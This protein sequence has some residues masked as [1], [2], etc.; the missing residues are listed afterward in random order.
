MSV[1]KITDVGGFDFLRKEGIGFTACVTEVLKAIPTIESKGIYVHMLSKPNDWKFHRNVLCQELGIGKDKLAIHLGH[2]I[3]LGL[4]REVERRN[5]QGQ[6]EGIDLFVNLG[7]KLN[8]EIESP[9]ADYPAPVKTAS[10]KSASTKLK[11]INKA[12]EEKQNTCEV[13][14]VFDYW[15][16]K[17]NRPRSK[18]DQKR[19]TT[20][21][22]ALKN[23]SV[24]DLK[25][26]IDGCLSS[27]YNI[28]N[29]FDDIELI[30]R[31]ASKTERYI[32]IAKNPQ[33]GKKHTKGS[34]F[35][36]AMRKIAES[37]D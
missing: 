35:M 36:E 29:G 14:E 5:A 19:K 25:D 7:I 11:T 2:L 23:Y 1:E 18:L 30:C 3:K 10:G 22:K 17:S 27:Q 28:D 4:V 8:I 24:S 21:E 26:A 34:A 16:A 32:K 13:E 33:L 12:K 6:F 15:K 31:N 20:I 9:Q 37:D